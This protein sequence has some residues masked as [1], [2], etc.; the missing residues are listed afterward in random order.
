MD[1]SIHRESS[2]R[3]ALSNAPKVFTDLT[4]P[5]SDS[6]RLATLAGQGVSC[7]AHRTRSTTR[8]DAVSDVAS[9]TSRDKGRKKNIKV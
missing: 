4:D 2:K 9:S 1:G 8:F 5:A 3:L 6:M 7:V